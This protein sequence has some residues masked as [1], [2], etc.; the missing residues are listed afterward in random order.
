[1]CAALGDQMEPVTWGVIGTLVGAVVGASASI[2]TSIIAANSSRKSLYDADNLKRIERAREFQR[3]NLLD[4]Q[5]E[6][7]LQIRL[8]AR[9]HLEDVKAFKSGAKGLQNDLDNELDQQLM[10][11]ARKLNILVQRVSND[12]LRNEIKEFRVLITNILLAKNEQESD[13]ALE[14]A[15]NAFEKIMD[16]AG[17]VLRSN[18]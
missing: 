11:S 6:L 1:M 13:R 3:N 16:Q 4:L 9:V 2:I 17:N 10:Q 14:I 12:S 5:E 18:Y 15:S 7:H 8:A